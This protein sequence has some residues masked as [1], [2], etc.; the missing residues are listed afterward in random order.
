M[1]SKSKWLSSHLVPFHFVPL[2]FCKRFNS[3][4]WMRFHITPR[5]SIEKSAPLLLG[6]RLCCC[7]PS[8]MAVGCRGHQWRACGKGA[9]GFHRGAQEGEMSGVVACLGR[10]R[11]SWNAKGGIWP[12]AVV[13][14]VGNKDPSWQMYFSKVQLNCLKV[15]C[16]SNLVPYPD[17]AYP[18]VSKPIRYA[19]TQDK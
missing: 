16:A 19:Q 4:A 18:I 9:S 14:V 7:C 15:L 1:N 3:K 10:W 12:M 2:P 17:Q 8:P 13:V 6:A 5:K 11:P